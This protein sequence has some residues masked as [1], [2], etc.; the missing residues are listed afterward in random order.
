M[1]LSSGLRLGEALALRWEDLDFDRGRLSVRRTFVEL[2]GH[3]EIG[4]TKTK[5]SR[6]MVE[7]GA[8]AIQ[9]LRRRKEQAKGEDHES[10]LIFPTARGTPMLRSNLRRRHFEPILERAGLGHLR[11]HDLRHTSTS[12]AIAEGVP[13]RVVADRLGHS[14]VRLTQDRY[15]HVLP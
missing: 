15:A 7:L 1:L 12:I 14:T 9:A 4:P 2:S 13:A 8:L 3:A 5:G 10:P 11:I 6:R